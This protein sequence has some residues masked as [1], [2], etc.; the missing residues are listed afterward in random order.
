METNPDVSVA[1]GT[2]GLL[3]IGYCLVSA[4]FGGGQA[5]RA[6]RLRRAAEGYNR[7]SRELQGWI[8]E[9][10]SILQTDGRKGNTFVS[11]STSERARGRSLELI[12]AAKSCVD[13]LHWRQLNAANH[14]ARERLIEMKS[15][16]ERCRKLNSKEPEPHC[17]LVSSG[18]QVVD[19]A[20]RSGASSQV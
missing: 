15:A 13:V 17:L 12:G 14:L 3:V 16:C 2:V 10:S 20:F 4:L 1:M 7:A 9:C 6:D 19:L 18:Q 5:R 11:G 8:G